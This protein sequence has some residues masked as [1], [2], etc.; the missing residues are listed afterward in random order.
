MYENFVARQYLPVCPVCGD[1][2]DYCQGHG[3]IGDPNGWELMQHHN[4][5]DHTWCH[6]N[7]DC[8]DF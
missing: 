4:D 8:G 3:P 6:P 1:P 5:G 7:S 2:I